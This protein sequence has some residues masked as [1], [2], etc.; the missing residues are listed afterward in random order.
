MVARGESVDVEGWVARALNVGCVWVLDELDPVKVVGVNNS[1][2]G[3]QGN[4]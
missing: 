1:V 2:G 4:W 3:A